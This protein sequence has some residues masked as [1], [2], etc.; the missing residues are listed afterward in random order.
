MPSPTLA[1]VNALDDD[2]NDDE[3]EFVEYEEDEEDEEG[4]RSD[5][6]V[7]GEDEVRDDLRAEPLGVVVICFIL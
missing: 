1:D 4:D 7:V 2:D 6:G 3:D 5:M